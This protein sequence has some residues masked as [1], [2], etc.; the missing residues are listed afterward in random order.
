MRVAVP[1]ATRQISYAD[2]YA[3]WERGNW[4]AT[5]I[6]LTRD[7]VDWEERMSPAE[8]RA[9][10]W[11]SALFFHGEDA[12]AD[13]LTPYIEAAPREEQQ[14]FLA[15]QQVDEVRHAVF[16]SRFL[17]EVAG[18]GDGT[19]G[20][21]LR[22]TADQLTWGH[23]KVFGRLAKMARQL[24]KDPSPRRLAAAVTLYHIVVEG[25]LAQPGQHMIERSLQ[26]RDLLPGFRTGM[27]NVALDEQ[28]HIA[29]G[30]RLLADLCE[31]DPAC[32]DAVVETIREV[33][34]WTT[35]VAAPPGGDAS[36]TEALGFSLLD[37]YEEG[38]RQQEGRLR[39]IGLPVDE[40]PRFPLPMHLPPR[41]RA[42]RGLV[43]LQAEC[44][45]SATARSRA[46][47]RPPRSSSRRSA[48]RPTRRRSGRARPSSG[49]SPTPTRGT[50][51]AT[52]ER[53]RSPRDAPRLPTSRC[54][55]AS[56]T[57]P[58]S[59]PAAPTRGSSCSRAACG[60]AAIRACC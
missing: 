57:S 32:A 42:R 44:S 38:A 58:T 11:L 37:L 33:L 3:R 21:T 15:T 35:A 17:H 34:P 49:T 50:C 9:A 53:R 54:A 20:G 60:P 5:E 48:V 41:E 29:F 46:T 56:T 24:R 31:H 30:V 10:L 51:A 18:R 8:R 6:D 4:R 59:A 52:T 55:R 12:V 1:S 16:F 23:R 2:L 13:D 43:L 22:A 27:A 26:E 45:A 7:R 28:R 19:P 14:Y 39:A 36:F 25:S 47:P 40:L